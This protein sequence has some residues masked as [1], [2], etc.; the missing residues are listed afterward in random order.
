[1]ANFV[2]IIPNF[3]QMLHF[4][5]MSSNDDDIGPIGGKETVPVAAA[6]KNCVFIKTGAMCS[7]C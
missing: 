5:P 6:A 4:L 7:L 3:C 1:M 2:K